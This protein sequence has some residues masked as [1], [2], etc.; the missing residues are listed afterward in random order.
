MPNSRVWLI[1]LMVTVVSVMAREPQS[2]VRSPT[3]APETRLAAAP[4]P[5]NRGPG[6]RPATANLPPLSQLSLEVTALEA[7]DR[8]D[9]TARQ[10]AAW[11]QLAP[12]AADREDR[13]AGTG[14]EELRLALLTLREALLRGQ[15]E[16]AAKGKH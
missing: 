9:L 11:Q 6:T 7:L 13:R 4:R 14:P 16:Q 10:L 15:D 12:G 2:P 1:L 8:L 5:V 3:A